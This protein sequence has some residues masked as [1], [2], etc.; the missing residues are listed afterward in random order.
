MNIDDIIESA[1][2]KGRVIALNAQVETLTAEVRCLEAVVRSHERVD[3]LTVA[4]LKA[5]VERLESD[6][7]LEKENE[8]RLVRL[9]QTAN[10]EVHGQRSQI[11][12]LIDNQTSLKADVER[13]RNLATKIDAYVDVLVLENGRLRKA[14]DVMLLALWLG[15]DEYSKEQKEKAEQVWNEAKEGKQS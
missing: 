13:L 10:N 3:C 6:L 8:D 15:V 12:A 11:A 1:Q 2:L 7:K 4:N 5:E 14:G 9:W